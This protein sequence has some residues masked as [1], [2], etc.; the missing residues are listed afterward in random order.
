[1]EIEKSAEPTVQTTSKNSGTHKKKS[2]KGNKPFQLFSC[3]FVNYKPSDI[4]DFAFKD[5]LLAVA[6]S[7]SSVDIYSY[8]SWAQVHTFKFD[9]ETPIRKITW[10]K[11]DQESVLLVAFLNSVISVFSL[12]EVKPLVSRLV[13]GNAIWDLCISH[14]RD[15]IAIA[16]DDGS[17]M[18][19]K[20]EGEDELY[21]S[22]SL[23]TFQEKALS[24]AYDNNPQNKNILYV[25][26]EKGAIRKF[27]LSSGNVL[28][29]M[30][31]NTKELVWKLL[32][33]KNDDVIAVASSTGTISFF[34]TKF[35]TLRSELKTHDADILCLETNESQSVIYA[36]GL[37]SKIVTLEKVV[38]NT[39]SGN[40]AANT[41]VISSVDRG[42]SHD[43][44]ALKLLA[45]NV[46]ISG[47]LTT[48]ICIY[49]LENDRFVER[50]G[51][52]LAKV[53]DDIKLR[54]IT[55]LPNSKVMA[56]AGDKS[57]IMLV[58][59]FGLEFW[60]YDVNKMEYDFLVELRIKSSP[61]ISFALASHGKYFAYSTLEETI[62]YKVNIKEIKI[63]KIK[64]LPPS[65]CMVFSHNGNRLYHVNFDSVLFSYSF[66][67]EKSKELIQLP[68]DVKGQ[69]FDV[70][71]AHGKDIL[72][73][74]SRVNKT[75]CVFDA[76]EGNT[77]DVIP[78]LM[79]GEYIS[80]FKFSL[81]QDSLV[82]VYESNKFVVYNWK[83]KVLNKWSRENQN[84]F[85]KGYLE[86]YN[87]IIGIMCNP[88]NVSQ[89]ILY[90]NYYYISVHFAER[91]PNKIKVIRPEE[92]RKAEK[93]QPKTEKAPKSKT[94][95]TT[96]EGQEVKP[97]KEFRPQDK[98]QSS[99][100]QFTYRRNPI[101]QFEMQNNGRIVCL[102]TNWKDFTAALP[103]A[104]NAKKYGL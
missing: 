65:S 76:D 25:G 101:I 81:Y 27:D 55:A 44:K 23:R 6:R 100:F 52:L 58:K 89:I 14:T 99:N 66:N 11:N 87:K 72:A 70:E 85:P 53:Q 69:Y 1:M 47:G 84:R 88:F 75:L 94:E 10:L 104:I 43:V 16:C 50:K 54:H 86:R 21:L 46:L 24:V 7:N 61:I 82:I 2:F 91:I 8:P 60:K 68:G 93:S 57:V 64:S 74:C 51:K 9:K 42:Q 77:V 59:D 38:G 73:I 49:N 37:D 40:R 13:G 33:I 15:E 18:I 39:E 48:D 31:L 62:L 22:R 79:I 67:N 12:K 17:A 20:Y 5:G 96:E 45:P 71:I 4:E 19:Y 103:G 29:T 98:T 83:E 80:C 97:K 34:E 32:S 92:K 3:P 26:Y 102:E 90:T 78:D 41:W 36:T 63:E 95:I 30:N 35:G 28:L 56:V